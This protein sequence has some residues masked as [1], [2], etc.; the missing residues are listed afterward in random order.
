MLE[1]NGDEE[2]RN[3]LAEARKILKGTSAMLPEKA[4][5]EAV[6][7]AHEAEICRV[8]NAL[9]DIKMKLLTADVPRV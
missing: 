3:F 2:P 4:H 6:V 7:E 5:L 8:I 9:H 1:Q